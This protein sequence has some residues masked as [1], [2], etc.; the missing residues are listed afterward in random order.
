MKWWVLERLTKQYCFFIYHTLQKFTRSSFEH[1]YLHTAGLNNLVEYSRFKEYFIYTQFKQDFISTQVT[2]KW[3]ILEAL[4][5]QQ[6]VTTGFLINLFRN[7]FVPCDRF[8]WYSILW[9]VT[10]VTECC[11]CCEALL[12]TVDT[13][14]FDNTFHS[15]ISS[16]CSDE[17]LFHNFSI[18]MIPLKQYLNYNYTIV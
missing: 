7:S 5:A 4:Y 16:D 18:L 15:I 11:R 12:L 13:Y 1:L 10:E 8:V 14:L 2:Y 3:N 9:A 6:I 17:R